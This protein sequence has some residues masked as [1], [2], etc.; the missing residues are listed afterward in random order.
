MVS[1]LLLIPRFYEMQFMQNYEGVFEF[2]ITV[3]NIR[4]ILALHC[5]FEVKFIRRQ[6]NMA[7]YSLAI[8][9]MSYASRQVFYYAP[10]CIVLHFVVC[11]WNQQNLLTA[12][13]YK[14]H[15]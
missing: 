9:A 8:M 2:S 10:L 12:R 11:F 13:V 1:L 3:A 7:A 4:R 15:S 14:M 5:K 6:T